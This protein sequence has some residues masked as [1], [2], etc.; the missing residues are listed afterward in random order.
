MP[1]PFLVL[2]ASGGIG[3]AISR[4]LAEEGRAVILHGRS[5]ER[6][7]GLSAELG[8]ATSLEVADLTVESE[9]AALFSRVRVAHGRLAGVVFSIAT[10]FLSR[11]TYRTPWLAFQEQI[12]SQLRALHLSASAAY[13]LLAG[14]DATR[15]LVLVSTEAVL[16]SGPIKWA[17]YVAAKA[18]MT[19]YAQVIAKEWLGRGV[20]VHIVAPGLVKTAL[21]ADMPDEFLQRMADSMPEKRLTAAE[22]VADLVAFLMTDAG[23]TLYGTPIRVSRGART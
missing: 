8:P 14:G 16:G 15:R 18:A 13:P 23:D 7:Q 12:D 5:L 6:L 3:S 9:V 4:R 22:D 21:V 19:A 1:E 11:L 17:P 20:R 10:P 2:G